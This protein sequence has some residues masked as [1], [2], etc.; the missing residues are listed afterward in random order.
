MV[1]QENRREEE[2]FRK[3]EKELIEAAR[4]AR[5]ARER[6]RSEREAVEARA[7]LKAAHFMKCPKCGHDLKETDFSGVDIDVC[8]YCEGVFF[9]AGELEELFLKR[10]EERRGLF[11]KLLRL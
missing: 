1:E 7:K 5:E 8:S 3:N 6:E 9:D 4:K 10:E 2:W 11:R